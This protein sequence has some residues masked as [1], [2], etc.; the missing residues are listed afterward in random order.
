MTAPPSWL[1]SACLSWE[2]SY[3][4]QRSIFT[5]FFLC[6][7]STY[8]IPLKWVLRYWSRNRIRAESRVRNLPAFITPV[9]LGDT[10]SLLITI[11]VCLAVIR[12][13]IT[14]PASIRKWRPHAPRSVVRSLQ[15]D[16]LSG[17]IRYGDC[18]RSV[19]ITHVFARFW[20]DL[21][22]I[23]QYSTWT[24]KEKCI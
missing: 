5:F 6:I 18:Q 17:P 1:H 9:D 11:T 3:K 23:A 14:W 15:L 13:L 10:G 21:C 24:T 7:Q 12:Q 19:K 22:R 2:R 20:R 16:L 4:A 8:T